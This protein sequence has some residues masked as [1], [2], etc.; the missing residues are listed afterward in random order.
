LIIGNQQSSTSL[1]E[2]HFKLVGSLEA[3]S[4]RLFRVKYKKSQLTK[5]YKAYQSIP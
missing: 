3:G 2:G 4:R 1:G 5:H